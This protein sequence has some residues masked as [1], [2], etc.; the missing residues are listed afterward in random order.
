MNPVTTIT[1]TAVPVDRADI[2]TDQI[3]PASWMKKLERTGY[4]AGLFTT[5]RRDPQFVLAQPERSTATILIGGPNFGCGSSREHAVW[6]LRDHGF[7]AV[8][9]PGF[10]DIH[11]SNL[12]NSGLVPVQPSPEVARALMDASLADAYA[13]ITIDVVART[14]SCPAAGVDEA[15]FFLDDSARYRLIIGYDE[16]DLTLQLD[17]AITAYEATRH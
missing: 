7:R 12:P 1:G 15:P 8:I 3:I 17:D 9:A 2:D 14:V 16:I 11:R 6:A 13:D 5:F 4:A 10:A